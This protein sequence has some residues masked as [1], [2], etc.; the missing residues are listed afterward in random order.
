MGKYRYYKGE[1]KNPF[2]DGGRRFWWELEKDAFL[3]KD[4]K[5]PNQL[6]MVMC[7]FIKHRIW[8]DEPCSDTTLEV[9][10]ER[11]HELYMRGLW[12]APYISANDYT[13]EQVE[14]M[15]DIV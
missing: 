7:E 1:A 11:A 3:K 10:Y 12:S 4:E 9:V 15:N 2:K 14:K 6:S 13:M 8:E 5:K